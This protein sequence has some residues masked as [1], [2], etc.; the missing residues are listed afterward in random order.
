V[1]KGFQALAFDEL[2]RTEC[3]AW[4]FGRLLI[5]SG[6]ARRG[7]TGGS[8][9]GLAK[10]VGRGTSWRQEVLAGHRVRA[11]RVRESTSPIRLAAASPEVRPLSGRARMT[12]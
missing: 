1:E 2:P 8:D 11:V 5:R 3:I 7:T 9:L 12:A 6:L 4:M 10:S